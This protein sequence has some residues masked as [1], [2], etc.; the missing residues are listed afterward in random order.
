M[1][2][3]SFTNAVSVLTFRCSHCAVEMSY[4]DAVLASRD[5]EEPLM[6]GIIP[7]L[8]CKDCQYEYTDCAACGKTT[9]DELMI[10]CLRIGEKNDNLDSVTVCI[11][12]WN[13]GQ[14]EQEERKKC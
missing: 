11:P 4:E 3:K 13:A 1:V 9:H 10:E 14:R 7:L 2:E 6:V 12:C 5:L 8:V